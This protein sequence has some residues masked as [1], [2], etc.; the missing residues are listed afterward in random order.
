MEAAAAQR[1]KSKTAAIILLSDGIHNS[2]GNPVDVA[3]KLGVVVHTVGVGASLRDNVAYRDIQVTGIDCPDRLLLN[4]MARITGLVEGIGLAG[5]VVKAIL[6]EDGRQIAET[7]VDARS[8]ATGRSRST[9]SSAPTTKGRHT[10]TVRVPPL[11]E[12]KIVENNQRS[13]A[14]MVVEPGIRVL[15]F[16]GT[17]R[18]EYGALVDRFLAKDPDLEFCA[19]VQ[20]RPNV[21][22]KR[23]NI[24][25]TQADGH[26]HRPGDDRQVRRLHP[27]R[28]GQ[29]VPPPAATGNVRQ[30]SPRR[31]R[32]W[33]CWAAITAWGRAATRHAVGR[34]R[35]RC[36]LGG[37]DIGQV[38]DA[39]LAAC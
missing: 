24:A 29:F 26:P 3:G 12:E 25:G 37:T 20:T 17:L 35:C 18:A 21:F 27:R 16:E 6:E 32:V 11:P 38:T 19:L 39:F 36:I 10:Y 14:A 33:S 8:R 9:S 22:L 31:G 2:A 13:A 4:N 5:R 1:Q 15:Y 23:S 7:G 34:S 30:A 28:L